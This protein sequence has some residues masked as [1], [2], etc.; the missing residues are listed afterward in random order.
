ML[1]LLP[2]AAASADCCCFCRMLLLLPH[3]ASGQVISTYT[4][5]GNTIRATLLIPNLHPPGQTPAPSPFDFAA[6]AQSSAKGKHQSLS[7]LIVVV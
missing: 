4:Y 3:V 1:L 2:H 6:A 5:R 7:T